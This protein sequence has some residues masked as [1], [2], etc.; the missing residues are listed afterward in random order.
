MGLGYLLQM[1]IIGP[2][3][4]LNLKSFHVKVISDN[5]A[6]VRLHEKCGF[7]KTKTVPWDGYEDLL[8]F[9]N[10]SD[11]DDQGKAADRQIVEMVIELNHE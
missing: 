1:I 5:L 4:L 7:K 9:L 2:A 6:S 3:R 8:T 10:E 11:E